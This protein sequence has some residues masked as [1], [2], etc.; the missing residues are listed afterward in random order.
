MAKMGDFK[1]IADFIKMNESQG[2][3]VFVYNLEGVWPLAHYYTG[4]NTIVPLPANAD[5][6]TYN[7]NNWVLKNENDIIASLKEHGASDHIWLVTWRMDSPLVG[8][9]FHPEIL[10]EFIEK[11]CLI[12]KTRDFYRARAQLLYLV[13]GV[14]K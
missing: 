2:Q 6:K 4:K 12:V 8:V 11:N 1:R 14:L 10:N 9:D 7:L 5:T 13:N 3:P